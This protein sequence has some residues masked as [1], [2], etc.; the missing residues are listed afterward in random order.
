MDCL[1]MTSENWLSPQRKYQIPLI[2]SKYSIPTVLWW[3]LQCFFWS[4]S[5]TDTLSLQT[6]INTNVRQWKWRCCYDQHRNDIEIQPVLTAVYSYPGRSIVGS[7]KNQ[8]ILM[9]NG[10]S[11]ISLNTEICDLNLNQ[12]FLFLPDPKTKFVQWWINTFCRMGT[13]HWVSNGNSFS[14]NRSRKWLLLDGFS[15]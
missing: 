13:R 4:L 10:L 12:H 3:H 7:L 14:L 6:A 15:E 2:L 9:L 8:H 5:N 1:W 11:L